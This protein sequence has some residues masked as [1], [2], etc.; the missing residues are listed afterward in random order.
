MWKLK[1][2]FP[3]IVLRVFF[4]LKLCNGN[5]YPNYTLVVSSEVKKGP[6]L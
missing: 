6:M 1:I 3:I 4:D 5:D 2:L